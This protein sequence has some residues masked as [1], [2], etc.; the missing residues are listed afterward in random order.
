MNALDARSFA[1]LAN[2]SAAACAIVDDEPPG[3]AGTDDECLESTVWEFE[4]PVGFAPAVHFGTDLSIADVTDDIV[5]MCGGHGLFLDGEV[6]EGVDRAGVQLVESSACTLG[7]FVGCGPGL[8]LCAT[9]WGHVC[10][11][12]GRMECS[13]FVETLVEGQGQMCE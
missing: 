7:C 2:L 3:G 5:L 6:H 13:D 12:I 9:D 8:S 11:D 1:I 4:C 10:S